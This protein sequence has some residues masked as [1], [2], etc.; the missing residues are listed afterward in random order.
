MIKDKI[1]NLDRYAQIIDADAI[2]EVLRPDRL[3]SIEDGEFHLEGK[4]DFFG[5][6]MKYLTKSEEEG[7]WEA[8]RIY[9]DIHYIISGSEIIAL[10]DIETVNPTQDYEEDYQLFEGDKSNQI[11]LEAGD[12]L[13]L[14]PNEVHK[15]GISPD[16]KNR[17]VEKIVFKQS[18]VPIL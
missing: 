6:K 1:Q 7:I 3:S 16:G 2:K 8:H 18:L 13:V 15:T 14:Y 5:I 9:L 11:K 10:A 17:E 4:T 12:F